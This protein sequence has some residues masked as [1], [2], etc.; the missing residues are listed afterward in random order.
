M[1]VFMSFSSLYPLNRINF[2]TAQYS[3][4][5]NSHITLVKFENLMVYQGISSMQLMPLMSFIL[6]A[7]TDIV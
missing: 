2:S 3:L 6:L 1:I 5:S 4:Y 7:Y